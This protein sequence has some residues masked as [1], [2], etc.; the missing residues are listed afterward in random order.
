MYSGF[1]SEPRL[2]AL[3]YDLEQA[4]NAR[5]QP[6]MLGSLPLEAP[7]AGICAGP[8]PQIGGPFVTSSSGNGKLF[9][10]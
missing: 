9:K 3:A 5:R 10:R 4:I 8:E 6:E 2:L 7:D 1:L